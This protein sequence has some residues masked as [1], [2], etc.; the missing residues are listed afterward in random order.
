VFST[1]V[2]TPLDPS[3]VRRAY[4]RIA[5]EAGIVHLHP[6][7]LRHAAASLLSAA[8]VPIED[9]SDTVGHR[10]VAVTAEIY[11]HPIAPIRSGH[12]IAMNQLFDTPPEPENA[13][14]RRVKPALTKAKAQPTKS[15][16]SKPD[17]G[18]SDVGDRQLPAPVATARAA[19]INS[20]SPD[21]LDR[22]ELTAIRPRA[23]ED[24][25]RALPSPFEACA[26]EL[27]RTPVSLAAEPAEVRP[28]PRP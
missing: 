5:K 26:P 10:S 25:F 17:D 14:P 15:R 3:N 9:I 12:M 18:A 21:D 7:M 11:L 22:T 24:D 23:R 19:S 16:R 13:K 4:N 28:E 27:S 2:G 1:E 20:A 6:H 8:G